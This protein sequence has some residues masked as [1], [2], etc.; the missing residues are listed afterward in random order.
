MSIVRDYLDKNFVASLTELIKLVGHKTGVYRLVEAGE[1]AK[2]H[3]DGLGYF[4]LPEVEEGTAHFAIVKKYYPQCVISGKTALALYDLGLDYIDKIEVDI[5]KSQSLRNELLDVHRV[6]ERKITSVI[7][8]SFDH[9]GIPFKVKIYSPERTLFEAYKYNKG[10][11]SYFY[12][13]NQYKKIYL[14]KDFPG[15]QFTEILKYN[16]KIGQD[17][18]NLLQVGGNGA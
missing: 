8:K 3:P 15:D 17:I 12:T 5:P 10:L 1:I 11:D 7:E 18:L 16:K 9:K 4:C 14:N 6:V 13:I 2:V